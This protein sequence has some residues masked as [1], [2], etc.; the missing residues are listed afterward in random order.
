MSNVMITEQLRTVSAIGERFANPTA[1]LLGVRV[2]SA[3]N[4]EQCASRER[5]CVQLDGVI[6]LQDG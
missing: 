4:G 6:G 3:S 5:L 1:G 2:V